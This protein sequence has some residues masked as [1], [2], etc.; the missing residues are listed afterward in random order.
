MLGY[1]QQAKSAISLL[2]PNEVRQRAQRPLVVGL[3]AG[4]S[5]AYADMEDFLTPAA[6][7]R[8]RRMQTIQSVYRASDSGIPDNY[9]LVLY[10]QGLPCPSTAFTFF[11]DDPERTVNEILR[12]REELE[13]VL[14]RSFGRFRKPVVDRTIASV[15]R[16]NAI[17]AVASALPNVIPSLLEIPWALGEFASDTA[18][19]TMNQVRMAFQIAAACDKPVGYDRQMAEL[20]PIAAGAFGWRAL[21]RELVGFIPLGGGLIPKG[22]I[23]FAATYVVGK[24][25]EYY[26]GVGRG[27]T[28]T[29][30]RDVYQVAYERGKD[31][32][33]ALLRKREA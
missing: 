31:L 15:A 9:D 27:Y 5:A 23:A 13:L 21:A 28:R 29:Q 25:L 22:A 26:Y 12:E 20:V 10:E 16:E 18:F 33:G 19:I 32:V 4:G 7:S 3:V 24:S 14:A 2:N 8:D 11:R 6:V 17:F 30:R 1:L